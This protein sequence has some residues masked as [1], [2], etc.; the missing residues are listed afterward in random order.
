LQ[1]WDNVPGTKEINKN[2]HV[3]ATGN[4][5]VRMTNPPAAQEKKKE[6]YNFRTKFSMHNG[7]PTG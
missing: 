1:K 2:Y 7:K 3:I 6:S 4:K 5:T